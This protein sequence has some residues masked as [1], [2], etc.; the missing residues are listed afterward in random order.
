MFISFI[1][2]SLHGLVKQKACQQ[3]S[4]DPFGPGHSVRFAKVGLGPE[5]VSFDV[6]TNGFNFTTTA[7]FTNLLDPANSDDPANTLSDR[8]VLTFTLN[9]TTYH[10]A[11]GSDPSFPAIP[12]D[13]IDLTTI[14]VQ[15]LPP[16]PYYENGTVQKV[17][18]VFSAPGT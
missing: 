7:G 2:A 16:N 1:Y 4:R 18:T 6:S 8:I 5:L 10:V 12:D 13:A 9:A 11:F 17:A 3:G 14:P 15:G